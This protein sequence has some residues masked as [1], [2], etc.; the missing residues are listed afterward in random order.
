MIRDQPRVVFD[1]NLVHTKHSSTQYLLSS[2]SCLAPLITFLQSPERICQCAIGTKS[3]R[4]T[5]A[6]FSCYA[7]QLVTCLTRN[8]PHTASIHTLDDYSVLNVFYLYRP[9][10]LDGDEDNS[11]RLRGGRG[12]D[13]E[14]WW[15][16]L[17]HVC[18]RWRNLV[19]GSASHL[20][21]CLVC[22]HGTPVA[23]ML[24]HSP[25]GPPLPLVLDY[26]DGDWEITTKEEGVILALGQ[27]DRVRRVRLRMPV[28]N[29]QNLIMAIDEEYPLLEYLIMGPPI[30]D[31]SAALILPET[32][33]APHLR[34]L[35]LRG[36]ALPMGSRLLM[37]AVNIVTFCLYMDHPSTYFQP[38]TLLHWIS[39]MP[40]L[41]SLLI[42][43]FFPIPNIDV[44]GQLSLTP[45]TTHVTLLNLRWFWFQG[46]S[47]YME[48]VVQR[49]TTPRLEKLSIH[50]FKQLTF[51]VP[52]L[53]QFMNTTENLRFDSAT[54]KFYKDD[55]D[56]VVYPSE[57]GE[58]YALSM[59]IYCWHLDWQVSSVAQ[60]F[61]LLGQ[62]LSTVEHLTL[63]HEVHSRSS[64]EHNEVDR[65]VWRKL[66]RS[67]RNVKT[68][69]VDDGLVKELSRC[70][71]LEDGEL[72]LEL[73][74]ELQELT[75]S[76]SGNARDALTS[77]INARQ[78]AGR[79]VNLVHSD[80]RSA[81]LPS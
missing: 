3:Q 42:V 66:L 46:V 53:L 30:E 11:V 24:A 78:V 61:N 6:F 4:Q 32:F 79:P 65:T 14:Q 39:F 63:K 52:R 74:P 80:P 19:L 35:V 10:I 56:V 77:F 34:H 58:M 40:L 38:N 20:G 47:A 18:Q 59:T 16:K 17:A 22:T 33:Q 55:I 62:R 7:S 12:W 54:F 43:F 21:L 31:R 13:R 75:Y 44:E 70:V 29:L 27:R 2:M 25:P 68:F 64:E 15:Y 26:L 72:P 57:E 8:S 45:I 73:L 36:F 5:Y 67:F 41:E 69:C 51:S 48:A 28:P 1:H 50:F 9:A 60:I 81:I 23:D 49:I 71:R 76:G 37:T